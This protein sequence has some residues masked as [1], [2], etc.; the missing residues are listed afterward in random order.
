MSLFESEAVESSSRSAGSPSRGSN[1]SSL[2][3]S[4]WNVWVTNRWLP[5]ITA[6]AL[7]VVVAVILAGWQ[8]RHSIRELTRQSLRSTLAISV[9]AVEFWL[10]ERRDDIEQLCGHPD[11]QRRCIDLLD[12]DTELATDDQSSPVFPANPET[13]LELI[14]DAIEQNLPA[15][16]YLGWI[17]MDL[18]GGVVASSHDEFLAQTLPIPSETMLRVANGSS[19]VC[20]P[21]ASPIASVGDGV[22]SRQGNAIMLAMAPIRRGSNP[23]G[24]L[25]LL[26]DPMDRFSRILS[27]AQ[28]GL[29]DETYAFDR[30]AMMISR[31]RFDHQLRV[32]GLLPADPQVTSPLHVRVLDP[33]LDLT[34]GNRLPVDWEKR[35]MTWMADQATRGATGENVSGYND[36]RGVPVVGAWQWLPAYDFGVTTEMDVSEAYGPM[37][38]LRN[39]FLALIALISVCVASLVA[40]ASMLRQRAA[41]PDPAGIHRQLG[42]YRLGQLIGHGGMGSVYRGKHELLQRDVAIKVLEGH[43]VNPKSMNRFEREVQLTSK[44]YHPNTIDIYDYGRNHDGTFYYVMDYV[45]G[46]SLQQLVEQFGRQPAKRVIGLLVQVCHSLAEAHERSMIH[47]D[48]KPANILITARAGIYDLVKVVD[49]GLVKQTDRDTVQLTQSDTITGSPHF[50]SPEAI[51]DAATAGVQSDLYSVGA[52]G[53]FLLTGVAMFESDSTA[54]VCARQLNEE[55]IRPDDVVGEPLPE[56]LQN[57]LMSCLRKEPEDRPRSAQELADALLQCAASSEWSEAEIEHWWDDFFRRRDASSEDRH[58]D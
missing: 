48:I 49:F 24:S 28:S 52:V 20:R 51:R 13:E 14:R 9:T 19:T 26:L 53:Y 22:L 54:D 45:D 10:G 42:Q 5:A 58:Q 12:R 7:L 46:I 57:V 21:L 35:P 29:T 40:L 4:L 3:G 27:S 11:I 25:G 34:A 1:D 33:G 6:I 32:A 36:Y 8:V 15:G 17:L 47:R 39:S 23:L 56:D 18:S 2:Q 31:S 38:I 41:G 30:S 37:R 43:A 44:L 50:M 16:Q 55:P